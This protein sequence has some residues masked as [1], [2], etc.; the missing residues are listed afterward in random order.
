MVPDS[1]PL[2]LAAVEKNSRE[3]GLVS[4]PAAL[5]EGLEAIG[6]LQNNLGAQPSGTFSLRRAAGSELG[7]ATG[8]S[9]SV[10]AGYLGLLNILERTPPEHTNPLSRRPSP[11]HKKSHKLPPTSYEKQCSNSLQYVTINLRQSTIS[12]RI[13]LY[14]IFFSLWSTKY[15]FF[16]KFL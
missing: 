7:A 9:H 11:T 4:P 10:P 14:T 12:F 8:H 13:R 6:I 5:E 15:N 1:L 3:R 2:L 16:M